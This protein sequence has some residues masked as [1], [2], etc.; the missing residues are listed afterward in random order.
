MN[1]SLTMYRPGLL[2]SRAFEDVFDNIFNN[3]FDGML[4]KSTQG[5]PVADIYS[6]EN[7]DTVM[8]FALAGFSKEELSIEVKPGDKSIVVRANAN[9]EDEGKSSRRIARRSFEK[10]FVNYDNNLDLTAITA[11]FENGLLKVIVPTRPD[12]KPLEV[13]IN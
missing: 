9:S 10:R 2:G 6:E 12:T 5:Y 3:S 7:G 11:S 13:K 4:R 1:T 8:E